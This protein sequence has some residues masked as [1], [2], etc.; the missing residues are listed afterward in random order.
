MARFTVSR[1]EWYVGEVAIS[2][3]ICSASCILQT[4]RKREHSA[5]DNII[6]FAENRICGRHYG[7]THWVPLRANVMLFS[8]GAHVFLGASNGSLDPYTGADPC[9]DNRFRTRPARLIESTNVSQNG[10]CAITVAVEGPSGL[11]VRRDVTTVIMRRKNTTDLR[12]RDRRGIRSDDFDRFIIVPFF[13][14]HC[15]DFHAPAS[16]ARRC[17]RRVI[18]VTGARNPA[19]LGR[20]AKYTPML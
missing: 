19:D 17:D 13:W 3:W 6:I 14:F 16:L 10:G 9:D 1:F 15:V 2:L 7:D 4:N 11:H 12:G 8:R 5:G 18:I 20:R